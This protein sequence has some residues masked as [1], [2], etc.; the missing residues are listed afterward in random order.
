MHIYRMGWLNH[1]FLERL[2]STHLTEGLMALSLRWMQPIQQHGR[3]MPSKSSLT[4][5]FTW[6]CLVSFFFTNVV[7]QIHSLRAKGV[8][9]SQIV[10]ALG[11]PA[12]AVFRSLGSVCII[13]L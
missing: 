6:S 5:L 8:S 13:K 9:P 10:C 4:T 2:L 11:E 3:R 7:Q 1:R 12:N